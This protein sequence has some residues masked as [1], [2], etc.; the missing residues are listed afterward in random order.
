MYECES[1]IGIAFVGNEEI[2]LKMRGSGQASYAQLYSRI[3]YNEH[4]MTN[5]ITKEDIALLFE[6]SELE[7]KA[8]DILFEISKTNYGIRGVVNVFVNTAAIFGKTDS[9][10]YAVKVINEKS[11]HFVLEDL[12]SNAETLEQKEQ[13]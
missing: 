6:E 2:Y 3:A 7:E 13:D 9:R 8:L 11:Y 12:E 1:G 10:N 5:S 4:I